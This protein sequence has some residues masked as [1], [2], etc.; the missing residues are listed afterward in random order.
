[1]DDLSQLIAGRV[2]AGNLL[3][4][5][6]GVSPQMLRPGEAAALLAKIE[7]DPASGASLAAAIVEG[8][9]ENSAMVLREFGDSA[10]QIAQAGAIL[11][12][13]G[14]AQAAADVMA[15]YQKSDNG[16]RP[17]GLKQVKRR[18]LDQAIIG[19]ALDVAP[20]ERNRIAG[21]ADAIARTRMFQMGVDPTDQE[22]SDEIY[23]KALHEAA[24]ASYVQGVQFGGFVDVKIGGMFG[25]GADSRKVM[26]PPSMRADKIDE[27]LESLTGDDLATFGAVAEGGAAYATRDIRRA[28]PVAVDGGYAFALGDPS[29]NNPRF[30]RKQ[31]GGVFRLDLV[32]N[33][34]FFEA[35]VPGAYR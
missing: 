30:L 17:A 18:A 23:T 21:A 26:V 12:F 1:M 9:G 28:V 22:Q 24:G 19:P 33:R 3:G 25:I 31:G 32:G 4:E 35:R 5:H 27:L 34:A 29:S 10:P 14:S 13:G 15:G 20:N 8:A 2:I 11:A 16:K 7:A 6:Y